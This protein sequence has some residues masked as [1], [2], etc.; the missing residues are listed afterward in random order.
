MST[1]ARVAT[2]IGTMAVLG[3]LFVLTQ[4]G[5]AGG[6]K[7]TA[8]SI[9][10]IAALLEKGDATAAAKDA[11]ALAKDTDVEEVMNLL[12]PRKKKGIGVGKTPNAIQP[13]GIEQ[14]Y[15]KLG[16]DQLSQSELDKQAT[17]LEHMGYTTAAVADFAL[18]KPPDKSDGKKT[19]QAWTANAKEMRDASLAFAEAA[20]S[21][22]PD[23]VHKA[24]DKVN[25]A[26]NNCHSVFRD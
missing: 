22:S 1:R 11:K 18:A 19:P 17:A 4:S 7:D 13:D 3:L 16:R 23:A 20:K 12:R 25:T 2:F 15:I 6:E 14:Q 9:K 8:A 26:C 24:A 21:K 10:Q 5:T